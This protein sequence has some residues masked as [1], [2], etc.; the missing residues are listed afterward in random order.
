MVSLWH[1]IVPEDKLAQTVRQA[2]LIAREL[3]G[4]LR[5]R[6]FVPYAMPY[7][8]EVGNFLVG[9]NLVGVNAMEE[10][11]YEMAAKAYLRERP[12]LVG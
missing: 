11:G 6:E 10:L 3:A 12:A 9:L 2:N 5:L 4:D 7:N 1:K 8:D